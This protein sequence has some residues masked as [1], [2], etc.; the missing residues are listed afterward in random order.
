MSN[1]EYT[2]MKKL[3][4][5]LLVKQPK[6]TLVAF[7]KHHFAVSNINLNINLIK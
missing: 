5:A 2:E 6:K 7:V 1:N 3:T 4:L